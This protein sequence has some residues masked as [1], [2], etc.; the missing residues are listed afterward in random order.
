M[1]Q[2]DGQALAKR[3]IEDGIARF[4]GTSPGKWQWAV[5]REL[6]LVGEVL[7]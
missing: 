5:R 2:L 1:F 6:G 7:S 3:L 4:N